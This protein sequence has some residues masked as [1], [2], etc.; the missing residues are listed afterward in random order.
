MNILLFD[1]AEIGRTLSKRDER[2]MHLR[3]VLRKGPGDEFGDRRP[4]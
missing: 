3:K 4:L 1:P 2:A